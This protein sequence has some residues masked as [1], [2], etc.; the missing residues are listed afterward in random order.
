MLDERYILIT[1]VPQ[2]CVWNPLRPL[3]PH[4]TPSPQL[5]VW[6]MVVA[7]LRRLVFACPLTLRLEYA[8]PPPP[9][10]RLDYVCPLTL[11]LHYACPPTLRLDCDCNPKLAF[12]RFLSPTLR[13]IFFGPATVAFGFCLSPHPHPIPF[14]HQRFGWIKLA[15][16]HCG[17]ISEQQWGPLVLMM[18][19]RMHVLNSISCAHV[20]PRSTNITFGNGYHNGQ[21]KRLQRNK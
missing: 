10:L 4:P 2:R 9:T 14:L 7:S 21:H 3:P 17:W 12:G 8:R 1:I 16:Q 11:H 15:P 13:L 18:S 6:F 19:P 5:C 20:T